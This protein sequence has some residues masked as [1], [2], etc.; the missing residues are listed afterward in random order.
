M[1]FFLERAKTRFTKTGKNGHRNEGRIFNFPDRIG[2]KKVCHVCRYSARTRAVI[3]EKSVRMHER[4]KNP[5][6]RFNHKG[7]E[8]NREQAGQVL[9]DSHRKV[10]GIEGCGNLRLRQLQNRLQTIWSS[11][12]TIDFESL[13]TELTSRP[14]DVAP[15]RLYEAQGTLFRPLL[16]PQFYKKA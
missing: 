2:S 13:K 9:L 4:M 15:V 3:E 1:L 16:R 7:H 10:L 5:A 14:P 11:Y 12:Q 8:G 6:A